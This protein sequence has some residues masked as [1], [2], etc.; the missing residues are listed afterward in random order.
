M[1]SCGRQGRCRRSGA[2]P[3]TGPEAEVDEHHVDR[4]PV[5]RERQDQALDLIERY[6]HDRETLDREARKLT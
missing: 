1:G 6:G 2:R 4:L 3:G 5:G